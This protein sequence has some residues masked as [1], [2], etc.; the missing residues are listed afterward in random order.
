MSIAPGND[1]VTVRKFTFSLPSAKTV[2]VMFHGSLVCAEGGLPIEDKVVDVAT[3]IRTDTLAADANGPGGLR[4]AVV[5]K[6]TLD[7][8]NRTTDTFN[9]GSIRAITF[10]SSGSKTV[11]LM[12]TRL[13]M[14]PTTSCLVYNAAFTVTIP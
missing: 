1:N 3:Q 7:N 4:H 14:D 5:L 6:D 10:P 2:L 11:R 12:L 13:R 8:I 9:L